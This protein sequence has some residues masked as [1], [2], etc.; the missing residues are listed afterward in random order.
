MEARLTNV[1]FLS[2]EGAVASLD[3]RDH[4]DWFL[5]TLLLRKDQ[6]LALQA[7]DGVVATGRC[8]W[9][10]RGQGGPTLWPEQ[11]ARLAELNLEHHDV[12]SRGATHS[13]C[14]RQVA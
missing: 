14:R 9:W 7:Q 6:L 12:T 13:S 2:S 8:I 4:L 11:M 3:M 5:T 10:S 1:F